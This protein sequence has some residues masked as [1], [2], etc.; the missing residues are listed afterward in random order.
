MFNC[1]NP[2]SKTCNVSDINLLL[3]RKESFFLHSKRKC[4]SDSTDSGQKGQNLLSLDTF[5]LQYRN[6]SILRVW[7]LSL[8]L[9]IGKCPSGPFPQCLL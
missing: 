1:F 4:S 3:M 2:L 9:V 5:G 6:V 7:Q 8:N